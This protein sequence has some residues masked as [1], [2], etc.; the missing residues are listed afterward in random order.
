MYINQVHF[1]K[2]I[3]KHVSTLH[4]IFSSVI[5]YSFILINEKMTAWN[6]D[7]EEQFTS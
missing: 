6:W 1:L 4:Y 7:L 5:H 3:E 2:Y